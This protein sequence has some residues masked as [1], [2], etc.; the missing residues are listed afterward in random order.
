MRAWG[1]SLDF[2]RN[3]T[4]PGGFL[5]GLWR[6]NALAGLRPAYLPLTLPGHH[7]RGASGNR[8]SNAEHK[9]IIMW[10]HT[11]V[12]YCN[13]RP[14]KG[15]HALAGAAIATPN[16]RAKHTLP[17]VGHPSST[18]QRTKHWS[19]IHT[20]Y[21]CMPDL[22]LFRSQNARARKECRGKTC[23]PHRD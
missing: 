13:I 2:G 4:A 14:L 1:K 6:P 22:Y 3:G 5:A 19:E 20:L 15:P 12:L 18:L 9:T 7:F 11:P 21:C 10:K 23:G 8:A 16:S 17:N